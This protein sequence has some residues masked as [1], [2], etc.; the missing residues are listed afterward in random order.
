MA[1]FSMI[2]MKLSSHA[3]GITGR[4]QAE[5]GCWP[6]IIALDRRFID[7]VVCPRLQPGGLVFPEAVGYD[8]CRA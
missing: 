6:G 3:L 2:S 1:D 5:R 4:Y 7:L 8:A